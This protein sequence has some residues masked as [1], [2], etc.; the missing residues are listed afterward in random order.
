MDE[1]G[2]YELPIGSGTLGIA[3][4]PGRSG[5]YQADLTSI[6]KWGADLVLSMTLTEELA[7][8]GA[9]DIGTDLTTA[10]VQWLHLPIPDF[11]AP[12]PETAAKW[13]DASRIALHIL[14]NGGRVLAHCHGGCGRSGMALLRLMVE[15]GEDADPALVRLRNVRP[16]AVETAE[17]LAWA[18]QPMFDR[19]REEK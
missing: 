7:R 13:P 10:D 4:M 6:L 5:R 12:P 2:I 1:F 9:D 18:A 14:L 17:Q 8:H 16:C 11:G 19:L 3:S 15:A